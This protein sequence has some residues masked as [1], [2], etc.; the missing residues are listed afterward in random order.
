MHASY[1]ESRRPEKLND[2]I[3]FRYDTLANEPHWEETIPID[4][5]LQGWLYEQ[6]KELN[7]I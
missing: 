6:R 1:P 2:V 5:P 7:L 3:S 4:E